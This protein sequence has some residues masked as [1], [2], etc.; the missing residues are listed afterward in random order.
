MIRRT[1]LLA[2]VFALVALATSRVTL[3]AHELVGH[4]L[5]AVALG[6]DLV[7][8]RLFL[9]GGGW[10][11]YRWPDGPPGAVGGM[12]VALG[13]IA[14]EL[15][16]GAA[17]LALATR[18]RRPVARVGLLA[19]ATIL[20]L[21][22]GFYLAAGTHHGFGDGRTPHDALGAWR[23]LLVVP[24]SLAVVAGGFALAARLAREV[25]TWVSGRPLARA[26]QIA[27]A[28]ILAAAAHGA[29]TFGE[30]ALTRDEQYARVMEHENV[31]LVARDLGKFAADARRAR[32]RAPTPA[33]LAAARAR[34]EQEHRPFPLAPLLAVALGLACLAGL[35]RAVARAHLDPSTA[36]RADGHTS[37]WRA[38]LTPAAICV[39]SVLLV[40]AVQALAP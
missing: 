24:V 2:A 21:H 31:R 1:L 15:V 30:R 22:A 3:V 27:A 34:L 20:L 17:A 28:A 25:V 11:S 18:A 36:G 19:T 16:A 4:G 7:G 29:L 23:P 38:A 6:A 26:G 5:T 39:A 37:R 9:F 14:L 32:G 8:Y 35:W 10:V 13:G 40:A 33:E 12:A